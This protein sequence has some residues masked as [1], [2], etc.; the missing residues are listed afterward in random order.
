MRGEHDGQMEAFSY[1]PL[2][3]RVPSDHPLRRIRALVEEV[4]RGM[5]RKLDGTAQYPAGEP[6]QGAASAGF[7]HDPKRRAADRAFK[8]QPAVPMVRGVGAG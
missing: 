3:A 4:L 8:I 7:V 6:A 1:I 2:E 5:D